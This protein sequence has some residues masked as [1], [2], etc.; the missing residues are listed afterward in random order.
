MIKESAV[1]MMAARLAVR[2]ITPIASAKPPMVA[3]LHTGE[4]EGGQQV[5]FVKV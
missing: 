5:M 3:S 2:A 4:G 1:L